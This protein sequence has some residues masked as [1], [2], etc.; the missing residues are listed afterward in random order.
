MSFLRKATFVATGGASGMV[1]KANSKKERIAKAMEE[2]V[3]LQKQQMKLQGPARTGGVI[4]AVMGSSLPLPSVPQVAPWSLA[5]ELTKLA[6]LRDQGILTNDEFDEQ[7]HRLLESQEPP[8]PQPASETGKRTGGFL[9]GLQG[10]TQAGKR[11][12][13]FLAGLQAQA[14]AGAAAGQAALQAKQDRKA[15]TAKLEETAERG[16]RPSDGG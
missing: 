12:G 5:D 11:T 16:A 8:E 3:R 13:G 4:P 1:F 6:A 14:Q 15:A 7:K 9:A 10:Q 2:Q